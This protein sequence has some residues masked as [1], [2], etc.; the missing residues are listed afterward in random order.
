MLKNFLTLLFLFSTICTASPRVAII[1]GGLSGLTAAYYLHSWGYSFDLYEGSPKLGGRI[2]SQPV[3]YF[4]QYETG[5]TFIN[6]DHWAIQSLLLDLGISLIPAQNGA[7]C[8]IHYQVLGGEKT[9]SEH[10]FG[11]YYPTILKLHEDR[12]RYQALGNWG[13]L[14]DISIKNYLKKIEAPS[15]FISLCRAMTRNEFGA[16]L[17]ELAAYLLFEL[18]DF[19]IEKKEFQIDGALGDEAFMIQGGAEKLIRKIQNAIPEESLLIRSPLE[20]VKKTKT[21]YKLYFRGKPKG[22]EYD[23]VILTIPPPVIRNQIQFEGISLP[24]EI[25]DWIHRCKLGKNRKILLLFDQPFWKKIPEAKKGKKFHLI[26]DDFWIW[27]EKDIY[28]LFGLTLYLGGD[29]ADRS[30]HAHILD[31]YI[32]QALTLLSQ[33]VDLPQRTIEKSYR[34][35]IKGPLW[36]EIDRIL[37]SYSGIFAPG[38]E[39]IKWT[40][41]NWEGIFFAGEAWDKKSMGFMDGAVASGKRAARWVKGNRRE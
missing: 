21:G 11:R 26:G 10:N 30:Y 23:Q 18:I 8:P 39:P 40:E 20:R 4:E 22:K 17:K 33:V 37:G 36:H 6:S 38:E 35:A 28:P 16:E 24:G 12:I 13:E 27:E 41:T 29:P 32:E 1:G 2:S 25:E 7:K 5:G 14:R 9:T 34:R 19:D 3:D 31:H 15:S